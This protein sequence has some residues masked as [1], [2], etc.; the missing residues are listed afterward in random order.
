MTMYHNW[1]SRVGFSRHPRS[2]G[3]L[4]AL[5][6]HP[7]LAALVRTFVAYECEDKLAEEEDESRH[8]LVAERASAALPNLSTIIL[9]LT[10]THSWYF[11][12][13]VERGYRLTRSENVDL[14]EDT[15]PYLAEP[16][17]QPTCSSLSSLSS[18]HVATILGTSLDLSHLHNLQILSTYTTSNGAPE[19]RQTVLAHFGSFL[20]TS[21]RLHTY[22][23][24]TFD[25]LRKSHHF[26][27]PDFLSL[28]PRDPRRPECGGWVSVS[29]PRHLNQHQPSLRVPVAV[30]CE[31]EHLDELPALS[32]ACSE[33]GVKLVKSRTDF[34]DASDDA[35]MDTG[36][37]YR[38]GSTAAW[39]K[40]YVTSL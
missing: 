26:E 17:R 36:A 24:G 5:E 34:F 40:T 16:L 12:R 8:W 13:F 20:T 22:I 7:H 14:T 18:L 31:L 6:R 4:E 3:N 38:L 39:C 27:G 35:G 15:A 29:R 37:F 33:A 25:P 10:L 2:R 9:Y 21:P 19:T 28:L 23:F 1:N 32:V 30:P 11:V